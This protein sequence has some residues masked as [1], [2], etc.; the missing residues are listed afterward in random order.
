[1]IKNTAVKIVHRLPAAD[2]RDS[3]GATMNLTPAQSEYLVTLR[4]GEAAVHADGMDYPVLARM[5]DGTIRETA[6]TAA[7]ASPEPVIGRRSTCGTDC[8]AAGCTLA[9]M[10]AAWRTTVTDP[11]VMMWAEL[12]VITHLTGWTMPLPGDAFAG[13]LRAMPARLRDCAV[14][15]AVD[16]AA[17]ARAPAFSTRVSPDMLAAHI[18]A[19]MR[20]GATARTRLCETGEPQYL[21]PA[22]RWAIIHDALKAVYRGTGK[23]GRHPSSGDWNASTAS[24]S[25][26]TPA[27]ASTPP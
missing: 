21:A 22:Y 8:R 7:T 25:P 11:R 17:A 4:P 10:R 12:A 23:S 24:R 2:D 19:A 15:H 6:L 14:S 16:Q 26:A 18:A 1:V 13:D 27:P 3:V 20:E 5:P 9:Q